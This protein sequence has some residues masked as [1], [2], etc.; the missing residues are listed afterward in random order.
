MSVNRPHI[1]GTS[2]N[3]LEWDVTVHCSFEKSPAKRPIVGNITSESFPVGVRVQ[4]IRSRAVTHDLFCTKSG[5]NDSGMSGKHPDSPG[6]SPNHLEWDVTVHCTFEKSPQK[7]SDS[8]E[9]YVGIVSGRHP[10]PNRR[11][12]A[13]AARRCGMLRRGFLTY[14]LFENTFEVSG[15]YWL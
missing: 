12:H 1:P 13:N 9:Y 2:P 14:R 5:R 10:S 6:T 15:D 8:Q 3:A 11:H 4:T 7:L